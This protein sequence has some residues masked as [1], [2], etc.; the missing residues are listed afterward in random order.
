MDIKDLLDDW[1]KDSIIDQTN[2]LDAMLN[3]PKLHAKYTRILASHSLLA[4]KNTA[5]YNQKKSILTD[6]Y[7]GDLN[8]PEDLA[9]YG[10]SEPWMKTTTSAGAYKYVEADETLKTLAFKIAY[11][12]EVVKVCEYIL[13]EINNRTYQFRNYNDYLRYQKGDL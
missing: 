1:E 11:Y 13:K 7:R 6:Y 5:E 4:K 3:T 9:K 12:E 10:F 2:L 8:N